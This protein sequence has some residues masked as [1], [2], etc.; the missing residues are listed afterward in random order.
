MTY[1]RIS[2]PGH[3]FGLVSQNNFFLWEKARGV[4]KIFASGPKMT[5]N[6]CFFKNQ[7]FFSKNPVKQPFLVIFG[8]EAKFFCIPRAF[9]QKKNWFW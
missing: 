6:G 8:P 5:G 9:S 2:D 4:Q 3:K 1:V 7:P